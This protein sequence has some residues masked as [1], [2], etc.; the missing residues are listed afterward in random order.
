MKRKIVH[1]YLSG[2]ME[3][4]KNEGIDWRNDL[5]TW[6][7]K[8]LEH[9]IFNPNIESEKYLG[10][11]LPDRNFRALKSTDIQAYIKIVKKF[12]IIDSKEIAIRSDYVVCYWDKSAQR[13][14][15]TKGELTI[16]R[17]FNKP[18]Y[19]VTRIPKERIPGWVLGCVTQFFISFGQLKEFLVLKYSVT[20]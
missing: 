10:K 15:G 17:Y 5:D 8:N 12:V 20:K 16:A 18:V 2:G 6:I 19:M 9:N 4:A 11:S 3:Y 13:G 1:V 14:A 7:R